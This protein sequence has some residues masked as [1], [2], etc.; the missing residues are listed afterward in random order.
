MFLFWLSCCSLKTMVY[1]HQSFRWTNLKLWLKQTKA[2]VVLI[3]SFNVQIPSWNC[4]RHWCYSIP[5]YPLYFTSDKQWDK[6]YSL[7]LRIF[8]SR[9]FRE[10]LGYSD[11]TNR[12]DKAAEVTPHATCACDVWL[13]CSEIELDCLM[14]AVATWSMAASATDTLVMVNC[15]ECHCLTVEI[16]RR[17][18]ASEFLAHD[19]VKILDAVLLHVVLHSEN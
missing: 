12:T 2:F 1:N 7:W 3:Q 9:L 14:T 13:A 5:L 10:P 8:L 11:C 4:V 16:V 15:R 18:K 6:L 19:A 17:Y